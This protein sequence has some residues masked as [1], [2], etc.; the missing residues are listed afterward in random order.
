M[1]HC[2]HYAFIGNAGEKNVR[3]LS[4]HG[5]LGMSD[6]KDQHPKLGLIQHA[7]SVMLYSYG[8]SKSV[9]RCCCFLYF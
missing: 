2:P 4:I 3:I 5:K 1:G 9:S 7:V 8:T 6:L